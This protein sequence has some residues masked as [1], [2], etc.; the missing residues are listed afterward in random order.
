MLRDAFGVAGTTSWVQL[1]TSG[2]PPGARH[3]HLLA[4]DSSL[5]E[6]IVSGGCSGGC[7]PL[8]TDMWS[9]SNANGR[10]DNTPTWTN[11]GSAPNQSFD[12]RQ[13]GAV[14]SANHVL[15]IFGGQNGGGSS[16]ATSGSTETVDTSVFTVT[17]LPTSG[18]PPGEQ[19]FPQGGYDP[20]SN[21]LII[22]NGISCSD[23][24]LWTLTNANGIGGAPT[25]TDILAQGGK[26]QPPVGAWPSTY[27]PELNT[28]FLLE[29]ADITMPPNL[30]ELSD[31]NGLNKPVWSKTTPTGAQRILA[32]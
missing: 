28:V 18:G 29:Q 11:R 4:Y 14:D 8:A 7:L 2:G 12:N 5:N 15:M 31:A 21:E 20:V 24:D 9:L 22:S 13:F 1:K 19:Y 25:W 32:C 6:L 30:W 16:C 10:D 23:N 3:G 17:T 27:S 26:N